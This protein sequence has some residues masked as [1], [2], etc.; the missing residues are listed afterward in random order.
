MNFLNEWVSWLPSLLSGLQVSLAV[1]GL[2]LL[3]GLPFGLLLAFGMISHLKAFRLSSIVVVEVGRG[4]PL[5]VLLYVVYF[6]LPDTGVVTSAFIAAVLGIAFNAGAY[7]S[8]IFRAGLLS[9]PR[10]HLEAAQSL[11]MNWRDEAKYIVLPQ[12]IRTIIPPLISYSVI[13][14]QATS[15]GYGIALPELLQKAYGIGSVTFE[16]L[17]VFVLVGLMYATISIVVSRSVAALD[18]KI[19]K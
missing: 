6:G 12:A 13:V 7:T 15:L 17:N 4:F 16:F 10:G 9:V 11:G 1:T 5:L 3:F 18:R 19:A 2:S 8:E 14:F